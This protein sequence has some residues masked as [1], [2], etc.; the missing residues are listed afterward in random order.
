M[1]I[2][3]A[4]ASNLSIRRNLP[5]YAGQVVRRLRALDKEKALQLITGN[6]ARILG[7]GDN[8][9]GTLET[10]KECHPVHLGRGCP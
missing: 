5:F 6:T 1:G 3:N 2:Q 4:D 9:T 8:I 7:I 10:G